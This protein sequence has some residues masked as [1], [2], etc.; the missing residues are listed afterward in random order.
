MCNQIRPLTAYKKANPKLYNILIDQEETKGLSKKSQENAFYWSYAY[1]NI[2]K[3]NKLT[4]PPF[5]WKDENNK[6]NKLTIT[7]LGRLLLTG[8]YYDI[9]DYT[10]ELSG[11]V[12]R[13]YYKKQK[14][15]ESFNDME[16]YKVV[17]HLRENIAYY[18]HKQEEAKYYLLEKLFNKDL[19][20]LLPPPPEKL[21]KFNEAIDF[22]TEI[23]RNQKR[24]GIN[25]W[26]NRA[27]ELENYSY[28]LQ[29][30][31]EDLNLDILT[32]EDWEKAKERQDEEFFTELHNIDTE[33]KESILNNVTL[34]IF[35]NINLE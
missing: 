7:E 8:W 22:F 28:Y 14:E 19:K 25:F 9:E 13:A 30:A 21:Q 34:S 11:Y 18:Y 32:F 29:E 24:R 26:I 17:K 6:N 4:A 27:E 1:V 33:Y 15:A 20:K 2:R 3:F 10:K 16:I 35:D 12:E 31:I 23:R 5:F